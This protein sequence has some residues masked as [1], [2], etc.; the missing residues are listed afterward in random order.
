MYLSDMWFSLAPKTCTSKH[1]N[2]YMKV[3]GL[4]VPNIINHSR[5]NSQDNE[6]RGRGLYHHKNELENVNFA[7][8]IDFHISSNNY[9]N[10]PAPT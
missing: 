10:S 9:E 5:L 2:M 8:K 1:I 3:I 4:H 7:I 6:G